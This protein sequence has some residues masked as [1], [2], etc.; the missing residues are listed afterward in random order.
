M[1]TKARDRESKRIKDTD[2]R[3]ILDAATRYRRE[4][5]AMER[6][7]MDNF[8]QD[9]HCGIVLNKKAPKFLDSLKV[10]EESR[11]KKNPDYYNKK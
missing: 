9:P 5:H 8:Q 4:R 1:A 2:T 7:E 10:K 11:K 3:K 6:L